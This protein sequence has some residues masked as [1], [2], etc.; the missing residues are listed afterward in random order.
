MIIFYLF[1][2]IKNRIDADNQ[3][4]VTQYKIYGFFSKLLFEEEL[5]DDL[6]NEKIQKFKQKIPFEKSWCKELM[7]ENIIDLDKNLKGSYNHL[8]TKTYLQL[9]LFNYMKSLLE[10]GKPYYISK[11][12]Y[13]WRELGYSA[14]A[15]I[16]YP[17]VKHENEQIRT[18]ALLAYISLSDKDPLHILDD[19]ADR[20][21]PIDEIKLLDIIQ[22]KKIKKP[23]FIGEW[24]AHERPS[25][26]VFA[27]KL[28]A[29]YNALEFKANVIALLN[30]ENPRIRESAVEVTRRLLI[31]DA[32]QTLINIYDRE[33]DK[34]KI[35]IIA[36]L[37]QIGSKFSEAFLFQIV[38]SPNRS[39]LLLAAMKGLK[40]L[41]SELFSQ[42][43][44]EGS[45]LASVKKHVLDPNI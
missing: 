44:P 33:E 4:K 21:S 31:A 11:V 12:I 22:R 8:L 14:S 7:I 13:F 16:I 36:S 40:E 23:S 2:I 39:E 17:Y 9:G 30:S 24:L 18:A 1:K 27:L 29:H 32:E 28:I 26:V 15:K 42:E 45:V 34:V 10:S 3:E 38:N 35:N 5:G 20:I 43:Y 25:H 19:Y 41:N 6:F 37:A